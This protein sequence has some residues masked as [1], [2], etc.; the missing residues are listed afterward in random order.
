MADVDESRASS[1]LAN[2]LRRLDDDRLTAH[3]GEDYMKRS[4]RLTG[5]ETVTGSRTLS[6]E[7]TERCT[8]ALRPE[9]PPETPKST[10]PFVLQDL[11]DRIR[12]HIPTMS[13][14][15]STRWVQSPTGGWIDTWH[16]D[17]G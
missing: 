11:H 5:S 2:L 14:P 12:G 10:D 9:L 17:N 15:P 8:R 6:V 1:G 4:C 13:P 7:W 3:G 16:P